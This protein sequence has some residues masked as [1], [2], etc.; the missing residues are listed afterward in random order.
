MPSGVVNREA[1][2]A[3]YLTSGVALAV[4]QFDRRWGRGDQITKS[5]A[6]AF[7]RT[8]ISGGRRATREPGGTLVVT[9]TEPP[10]TLSAP[11]TVSPPRTVAFA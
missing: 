9:N 4:S 11:R 1:T 2:D 7:E 5:P 3:S 8:V 10:T 6:S